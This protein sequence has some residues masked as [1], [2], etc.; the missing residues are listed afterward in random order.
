MDITNILRYLLFINALAFIIYGIDKLKAK[1][2]WWRI[3]EYTL[4]MVAVIGGS[5]GAWLGVRFFHHKTLHRKF[6]WGIPFILF[7]QAIAI[8]YILTKAGFHGI[9]PNP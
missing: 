7:L 8:V 6:Q 3:S 9:R 5:V 2:G 1:K 4:F